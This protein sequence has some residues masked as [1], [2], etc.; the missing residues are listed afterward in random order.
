M[1][2]QRSRQL[3][4]LRAIAVLLVLGCHVTWQPLWLRCGWTGVDLFFVLSGF[5]IAGLLFRE[6]K[7]SGRL[8]VWR[9]V[10]RR[11]MKIYPPYYVL[12]IGTLIF[13]LLWQRAIS[14]S[15]IWPDLIFVQN[16][17]LGLWEHLW[18][19]G[20]EEQFYLLL[21]LTLVL[22]ILGRRS[23]PFD[24]IPL[25]CMSVM[26]FC[27]LARIGSVVWQTNEWWFPG[28]VRG[29]DGL[30]LGVTV[31]YLSE[32]RP[33]CL[34]SVCKERILLLTASLA[35]LLPAIAYPSTHPVMLTLGLTLIYF[36]YAGL[37]IY[38]LNFVDGEGRAIRAL[39]FIGSYSYTIYLFHMPV[40]HYLVPALPFDRNV[41]FGTY[42]TVSVGFGAV[43]AKLIERPVLRARER[44]FPSAV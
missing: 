13:D 43:M 8:D 28:C 40:A 42:L 11:A 14:W 26:C 37:L 29:F 4:A 33:E 3:D 34:T 27:L 17:R 35:C 12:L 10:L 25:I 21:P 1:K 20:T 23:S 15:R 6:Y 7:A 24:R 2:Q 22:L 31:A 44:L 30:A 38:F 9:F 5:L 19:I 32:F 39:A 36:G 18:S 16:Y 41:V